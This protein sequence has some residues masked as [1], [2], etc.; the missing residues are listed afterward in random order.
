MDAS[1]AR[2]RSRCVKAKR[3]ST[4]RTRA[5]FSLN[6]N[7]P[8]DHR[9]T[10]MGPNGDWSA[11]FFFEESG[12]VRDDETLDAGALLT[13]LQGGDQSSN[14]ERKR[15]GMPGLHTY[16]WHVAPH[17]DVNTSGAS[18]GCVRLRRDDGT[19]LVNYT[20]RLLGRRG[21]MHA[22]VV[23]SPQTLDR[24]IKDFKTALAGYDYVTGE[25]YAE[26]RSG[27]RVAEYGLAALVLGGAAA[28]ATKTGFGKAIGKFLVIGAVAAGGAVLAFVRRFFG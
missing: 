18:S 8:R 25:R 5:A 26:F 13:S 2:P 19:L 17:Y 21:V 14:E 24:D 3:F 10:S 23:S 22:H 1:G 4:P 12:Y 6:E 20:I 27:D 28:V 16:G 7:P 11:V 9:Y 15:L